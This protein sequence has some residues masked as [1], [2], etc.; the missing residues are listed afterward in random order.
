MGTVQ[1]MESVGVLV[2]FPE[3]YKKSRP[4]VTHLLKDLKIELN[5]PINV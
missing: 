4:L 2:M 1:A 5:I 3:Q